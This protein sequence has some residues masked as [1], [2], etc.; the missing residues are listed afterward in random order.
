MNE[1]VDCFTKPVGALMSQWGRVAEGDVT[2]RPVHLSPLGS[3]TSLV[4]CWAHLP[5]DS[6][7]ETQA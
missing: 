5:E 4:P 6:R 1:H 7:K 3:S 2:P